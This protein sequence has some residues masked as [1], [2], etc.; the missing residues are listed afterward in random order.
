MLHSL[1][2]YLEEWGRLENIN[3]GGRPSKET[4][5]EL[6][7]VDPWAKHPFSKTPS[8]LCAS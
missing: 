7:M 8:N 5:K 2:D 1:K 3:S 4:S 6:V